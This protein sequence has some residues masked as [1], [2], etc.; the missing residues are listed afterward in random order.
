M[1]EL[2]YANGGTVCGWEEVDGR[3]GFRE[4]NGMEE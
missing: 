4:V 3:W 2:R 1:E